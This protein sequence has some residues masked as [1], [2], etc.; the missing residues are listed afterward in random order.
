MKS[1]KDK[2]IDALVDEL[3]ERDLDDIR[4]YELIKR[5]GVS[6]ATY[7]YYFKSLEDVLDA[8]SVASLMRSMRR[9][10]RTCPKGCSTGG[11]L[12]PCR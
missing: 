12:V 1:G 8:P 10:K 2:I 6:H 7:Y 9:S 5:S 3:P 11:P 4:E